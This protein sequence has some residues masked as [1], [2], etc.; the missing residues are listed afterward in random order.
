MVFND[1][2]SIMV[3]IRV[4]IYTAY[5]I[6]LHLMRISWTFSNML[7]WKKNIFGSGTPAPNGCWL[8]R[9]DFV[10]YHGISAHKLGCNPHS[11]DY[12]LYVLNILLFIIVYYIYTLSTDMWLSKWNDKKKT[13]H[14]QCCDCAGLQFGL[15]PLPRIMSWIVMVLLGGTIPLAKITI[16]VAP[17]NQL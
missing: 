4:Y 17:Q 15:Q 3:Y 7:W 14:L 10:W 6:S 5:G 1:E 13:K 12:V 9:F 11:Y 8:D 16:H 2:Y